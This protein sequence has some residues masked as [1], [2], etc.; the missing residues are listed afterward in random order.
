MPGL[1]WGETQER[2]GLHSLQEM[3]IAAARTTRIGQ[4]SD[5]AAITTFL[6]SDEAEWINGQCWYIGGAAHMRQ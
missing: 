4:P 2:A 5:L 3:F 1:V 6:L